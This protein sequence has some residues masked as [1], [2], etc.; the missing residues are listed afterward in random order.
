MAKM[1]YPMVHSMFLCL[2]P[3][4]IFRSGGPFNVVWVLDCVL[5]KKV[6]FLDLCFGRT[7]VRL[8]AEPMVRQQPPSS[9]V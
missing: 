6:L 7:K 2:D 5:V 1:S 4:H 8:T 9:I 3:D